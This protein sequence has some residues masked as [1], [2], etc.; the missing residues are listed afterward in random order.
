MTMHQNHLLVQMSRAGCSL[1]HLALTSSWASH[2]Q[3]QNFS[4][5]WHHKGLEK[6]QG[7]G[8]Q[9]MRFQR[10]ICSENKRCTNSLVTSQ[11]LVL[12]SSAPDILGVEFITDIHRLP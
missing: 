6:S 11:L 9:L 7:R 10:V 3:I 1:T 8:I 5:F 4:S 12:L 2:C